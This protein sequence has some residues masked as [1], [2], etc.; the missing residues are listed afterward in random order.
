MTPTVVTRVEEIR[1][2]VA[3]ARAAGQRIGLVP[4]MGALHEGHASLIRAARNECGLVVVW[5]FVNPAQFGPHE[6]LSR[7]PRPFEKDVALCERE[8]VDLLFA[9]GVEEV[10][11]EGFR[12]VVEVRELQDVLEGAA[13]PGHFRGVCT[14]VLTML[15]MVGPDAVYFGQKD[16]QQV[17]VLRRMMRDLNVPAALR[18]SPT[19][20]EADGLALSSRN[21]YLS[22]E[23]RERA[24]VLYR[25]LC[26][27]RDGVLAGERDGATVRQTME[28]VVKDVTEARLEYAAIVDAET[29][30]PLGRLAGTV[31]LA[32]AVR[33]GTTRLIDN[34]VLR[35]MEQGA[36]EI[37]V[38][39]E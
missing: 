26:A 9:P 38:L 25:A 5:L 20:R 36:S 7:Y 17:I 6:D 33:L 12:T 31:L 10:Y 14:V 1:R 22:F 37:P 16:A 34:L 18:I 35:V 4:T 13:R 11:P 21:Q 23:E 8:G 28:N 15:N 32:L 19:I 39:G 27:G 2:A 24:I 3:T 30:A 29:L